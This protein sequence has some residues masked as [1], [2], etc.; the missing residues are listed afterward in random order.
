LVTDG[1]G[2]LTGLLEDPANNAFE[3]SAYVWL[4]NRLG[5]GG[6]TY[7]VIN[8][9]SLLDPGRTGTN[10][11]I[12]YVTVGQGFFIL[13]NTGA[14]GNL[15]FH[16]GHRV[17]AGAN[18]AL[19]RPEGEP[20]K[21]LLLGVS[22]P[23]GAIDQ[24]QVSLNPGFS[25]AF[26]RGH[27]AQKID[28]PNGLSLSLLYQAGRQHLL[29]PPEASGGER[30]VLP[31]NVVTSS[32][33][34]HT[35][36]SERI[37]G[38]QLTNWFLEDRQTGEFYYLQPGRNHTL[39]LQAG[40]YHDRFYLSQAS[41]VVGGT[42]AQP[43][44]TLSAYT[45]GRDLFVRAEGAAQVTV[46]NQLGVVVQRFAEVRG[47]GLRRLLVDVPLAGVY[48]VRVTT[49]TETLKQRIWLDIK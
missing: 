34:P 7:Q 46:Y 21:H 13:R 18:T 39:D 37:V 45:F 27:D 31:L 32:S 17:G 36:S 12:N 48:L 47:S 24:C 16:N 2:G 3:G 20:S 42:G 41:E 19:F 35:F 29:A 14:S 43:G 33:G 4:D 8:A 25:P 26:D 38:Q 22:R 40:N 10:T 23:D 49:A 15:N 28:G 1:A 9:S 6:G 30:R 5:Q 11:P 44:S